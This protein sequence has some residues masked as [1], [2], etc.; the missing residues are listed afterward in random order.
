MRV[1]FRRGLRIGC[2]LLRSS[3]RETLVQRV[4]PSLDRVRRLLD[5][6]ATREKAGSV[7]RVPPAVS[8]S[9]VRCC[10]V[11]RVQHMRNDV[12]KKNRL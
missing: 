5:A 3:E 1:V 10:T 2:G 12:K 11:S 6:Q 8:D 4:R 9:R 7:E